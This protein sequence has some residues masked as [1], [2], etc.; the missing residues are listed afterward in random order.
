MA[1]TIYRLSQAQPTKMSVFYINTVL[2]MLAKC[3]MRE[4]LTYASAC[5]L[6]LQMLAPLSFL[7]LWGKNISSGSSAYG[8]LHCLL[9]RKSEA[10]IVDSLRAE[11]RIIAVS[12]RGKNSLGSL[13]GRGI[14]FCMT[15]TY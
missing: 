3:P 1:G 9:I 14:H 12:L 15:L 7:A 6:S 8:H 10:K 4:M 2:F 11:A 13:Y 5:P